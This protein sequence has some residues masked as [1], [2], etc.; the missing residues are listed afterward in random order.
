MEWV[1]RLSNTIFGTIHGP[2]FAGGDCFGSMNNNDQ[3]IKD[4][5]KNI[6]GKPLSG[7]FHKYAINWEPN[8]I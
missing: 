7:E 4:R 8:K 3:A 1:G 2:G 5:T 6:L